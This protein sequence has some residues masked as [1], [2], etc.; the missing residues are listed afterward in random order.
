VKSE[1]RSAR[2]IL[3]AID[4]G[5]VFISYAPDGPTA[6]LS[7]GSFMM[8]DVVPQETGQMVE[9]NLS[10]LQEGDVVRIISER[11]E[12]S[13]R[14]VRERE[15]ELSLNWP[16]H[17]RHFFRAEVWRYFDVANQLLPAVL[18]NPIYFA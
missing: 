10:G 8:G 18:T 15:T 12:E 11:G 5:R 4:Q 16:V 13:T 6:E 14:T 2:G 1:S 7:C 9:L 17:G 3:R